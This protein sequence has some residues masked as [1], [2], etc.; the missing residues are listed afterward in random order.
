MTAFNK[1]MLSVLILPFFAILLVDAQSPRSTFFQIATPNST[2]DWIEI[3]P[4]IKLSLETFL[5]NKTT[6]GLS[7]DD[8][9]V[10]LKTQ[11][12]ANGMIHYRYQQTFKDIPVAKSQ[13]LVHV[14]K[15]GFVKTANGGLVR[16]LNRTLSSSPTLSE[17]A[18]LQY[19]LNYM[20]AEEYAWN[21]EAHE[22]LLKE[23]KKD[24]NAT[25]FPKGILQWA[26]NDFSDRDA[27]NY[28][29]VYQFD[30]YATRPSQHLALYI[31][32]QNGT[33]VNQL[34]KIYDAH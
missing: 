29:L 31:D 4:E 13:L 8:G 26:S 1:L 3:R 16:Q 19:A 6:L 11:T 15:E 27:K 24:P 25:F 7:S 2:F 18:A 33:V 22:R 14:S 28:R 21:N 34:T 10:L 9:F 32:A 30:V 20:N 17:P 23:I 5:A 12:G